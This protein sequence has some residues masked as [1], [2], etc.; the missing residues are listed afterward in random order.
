M[1]LGVIFMLFE[2]METINC[3]N[4]CDTKSEEIL[5]GRDLLFKKEG[6]WSV[7]KCRSC[8][9]MWTNPRP[10]EQEI[11]RYYPS[12]YAPY[13][14][15]SPFSENSL[16]VIKQII[17]KIF[18]LKTT[19][20]P[21]SKPG[22]AL[23]VGCAAGSYL[24]FVKGKGW[25]VEGIELNS[26]AAHRAIKNGHKVFVGKVSDFPDPGKKYDLIVGWMVVEHLHNPIRDLRFLSSLLND[27]GK[28]VISV[29]NAGSLQ[30]KIFLSYWF[31]LQLPTHLFHYDKKSISL[32]LNK[33]GFHV[34]SVTD[35][36]V[37]DDIFSSFGLFIKSKG[38][39]VLG[40]SVVN[41][42]RKSTFIRYALKPI[43]FVF[44]KIN[45]TAR[46]TLVCTKSI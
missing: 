29:P 27:S 26:S 39:G 36:L 12:E 14:N 4:G 9:L 7:V 40:D 41:I 10:T 37:I 2:N 16:S 43:A 44:S 34:V 35:Q 38:F 32:I 22:S 11:H 30:F 20:T 1:E 6:V 8:G 21:T 28:L 3:A 25:N 15:D 13:L 17:K 45:L 31:P 5:S 46:M 33:A 19:Y 23:E 18:D 24:N 42:T